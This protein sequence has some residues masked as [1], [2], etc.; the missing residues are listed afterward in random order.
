MTDI[1]RNP[2]TRG[3]VFR[4]PVGTDDGEAMVWRQVI[5]GEPCAI[6]DF[7]VWHGMEHRRRRVKVDS[8]GRCTLYVDGQTVTHTKP[9]K[10]GRA[11]QAILRAAMRSN[12]DR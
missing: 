6:V 11:A 9:N 4:G 10:Y 8:S 3:Y 12:H 5:G 1:L 7:I 2:R